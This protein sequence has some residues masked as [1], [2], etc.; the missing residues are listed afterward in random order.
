M[1]CGEPPDLSLIQHHL[2]HLQDYARTLNGQPEG[3]LF[4]KGETNFERQKAPCCDKA[5]Q[6]VKDSKW[7]I[8][9]K[10]GADALQTG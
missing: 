3:G 1:K 10:R 4:S 9:P 8:R 5:L 2:S 6:K 7:V